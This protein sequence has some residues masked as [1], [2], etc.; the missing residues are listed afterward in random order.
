MP[1]KTVD[2]RYPTAA[3]RGDVRAVHHVAADVPL[4]RRDKRGAL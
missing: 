2:H 3:E 4:V 1:A